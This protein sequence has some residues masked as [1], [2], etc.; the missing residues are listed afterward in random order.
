MKPTIS[1]CCLIYNH[2]KYLSKAIDSFLSQKG[3]FKLEIVVFDDCSTDESRA[4]INGYVKA[5]P[6]Y[7][8]LIYPERN[9]YSQGKTAYFDLISSSTG[10]YIACCE[11]DDYWIDPLKLQKQLDCLVQFN[12]AN[13]VFHPALSL[14][15]NNVIQDDKYGFY[16]HNIIEKSFEDILS[17]SGGFMP[18]ASIFARKTA[19]VEWFDKYPDFFSENMWHS[20]I[21][22]LA[23]YKSKA[24]Y[25]PDTMCVYRTMH[26]GSWSSSIS[27]SSDALITNHMSFIKRNRMLNEIMNFEYK[28]IF[29]RVL[30][31]RTEKVTRSSLLTNKE[32]NLLIKLTKY[33]FNF[34]TK[35]KFM[36]FKFISGIVR[37]V[38]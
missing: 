29:D 9:V 8:K 31:K 33:K 14:H 7:F 26:E 2:D 18:M 24:V 16:G 25:L 12:D 30:I 4:I 17:C 6:E 36:V 21:Q 23:A 32:K 1:I 11:G 19:Y 15:K 37:Y 22:I 5:F 28:I 27:Q 38:R 13:L 34:I 10:E 35:V 20:T 3:G